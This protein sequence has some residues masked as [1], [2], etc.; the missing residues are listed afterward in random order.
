MLTNKTME[1]ITLKIED[2]IETLVFCYEE[3]TEEEFKAI[4]FALKV[5]INNKDTWRTII[6]ALKERKEER[7]KERE[8]IGK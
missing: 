7:K 2:I 6:Y 1:T 3:Q 8:R 5:T 4:L